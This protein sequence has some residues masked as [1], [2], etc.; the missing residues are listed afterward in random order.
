M[1]AQQGAPQPGAQS[2]APAGRAASAFAVL[3]V[4]RDSR[5]L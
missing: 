5:T 4:P 2:P 3:V 1:T